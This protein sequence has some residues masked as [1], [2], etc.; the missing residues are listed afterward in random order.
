[1]KLLIANRGEIARRVLRTA[2]RLGISTCVPYAIC[3]QN[4]PFVREADRAIL[5]DVEIPQQA[6]MNSKAL[7]ELMKKE[8]CTHVHPGYGFLSENAQ[9]VSDLE[10]EGL[11]F[12]GPTAASIEALGD[13]Q[14]S[15]KLLKNLRIPLVESYDGVDQSDE[16]FF[17]EAERIG[18]PLLIKPAAGGGGKGMI[19]I[20]QID[21]LGPGLTSAKR[22]AR[23][24]FADER[25]LLER[26]LEKA[27]H[28]EVQVFG[29][30]NGKVHLLGERECSL[31]R[32]HQKIIEESPCQFLPEK[33]REKL[34]VESRKLAEHLNYRSAGTLEWMWDGADG[35]FFLE[36]NTRLQ[37]EHPVTEKVFGIDLVEWQLK[38]GMMGSFPEAVPT[39]S[40]HSIEVRICAE[41]PSQ[42]FMPS[43]GRIHRLV[44]PDENVRWDFGYFEKNEVS[45]FFDSLLGKLIV[46]EKSR[47]DCIE[48]LIGVLSQTRIVGPATNRAYLLQILKNSEFQLGQL[49]TQFLNT[50]PPAFDYH[51]ALRWMSRIDS[52]QVGGEESADDHFESDIY[53]PW[54]P[55][56][57]KVGQAWWEDF[58]GKRY[59]SLDFGDWSET[60][61]KTADLSS[62]GESELE[63]E[64][65]ILSPMPCKI[66]SLQCSTDR[67][68]QKGETL[69]IL[70]AMKMEHK[71][72]AKHDC[73]ITK[74]HVTEGQQVL[75]DSL[76]LELEAL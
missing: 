64:S 31:Q 26:Y 49:S 3:D 16:V 34:F 45:S 48:K 11:G 27:R 60:L 1:M 15:K 50:L 6:Y 37:V 69:M 54:G 66:V 75:P 39:A 62:L 73:R 43:G 2:R 47:E 17:K 25:L 44:L 24:S 9:F 18:F 23:S 35:I 61:Q 20:N 70:E 52:H 33:I 56:E 21:D 68:F 22:I 76:L 46:W 4:L 65:R 63:F 30:G 19:R 67:P 74:I 12:I 29:D 59:F 71:I 7:I 32:R 51:A 42:D 38:L 28:I 55:V 53:S 13:K 5:M 10:A 41:D 40:G 8:A 57:L 72:K 14:L 58:A 36:M